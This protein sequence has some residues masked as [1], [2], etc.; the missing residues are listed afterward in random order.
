M[1]RLLS[2]CLLVA[3]VVI[4]A[5][6]IVRPTN[7]SAASCLSDIAGAATVGPLYSQYWLALD[8]INES[9]WSGDNG[10]YAQR[11]YSSGALSYNVFVSNGNHQYGTSGNTY[12]RTTID[13]AGDVNYSWREAQYYIC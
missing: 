5:V 8:Y 4:T 1:Q 10:Y 2:A 6:L 13:N 11:R 12:R 9:T 7:A 3:A